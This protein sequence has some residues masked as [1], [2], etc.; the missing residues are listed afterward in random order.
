M[1]VRHE[2]RKRLFGGRQFA[3]TYTKLSY[4]GPIPGMSPYP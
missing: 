4:C 1:D 3:G 2:F